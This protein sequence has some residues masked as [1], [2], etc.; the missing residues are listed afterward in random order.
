MPH[1]EIH[2]FLDVGRRSLRHRRATTTSY[3]RT[4]QMTGLEP[5]AGRRPKRTRWL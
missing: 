3:G 2:P 5:S 1:W 4:R